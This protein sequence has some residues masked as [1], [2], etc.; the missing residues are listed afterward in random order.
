MKATVA[1]LNPTFFGSPIRF[2]DSVSQEQGETTWHLA[3]QHHSLGEMDQV[4]GSFR[5]LF[6]SY[7][8][9]FLPHKSSNVGIA[10]IN[11][12]FLMVYTTHLWRLATLIWDCQ[13][14]HRMDSEWSGLRQLFLAFV[15]T[16]T[17]Q[18]MC[19]ADAVGN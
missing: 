9:L 16:V 2:P 5:V 3:P 19:Y 14:N 13:E 15:A 18:K 1:P 10:I 12:Q 17:C 7:E 6:T 11:H 4:F 8:P